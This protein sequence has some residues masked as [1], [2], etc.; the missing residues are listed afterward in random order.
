MAFQKVPWE[1]NLIDRSDS[2]I[3]IRRLLG[4]NLLEDEFSAPK[5]H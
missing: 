3:S 2:R 1:E 4:G 5:Q